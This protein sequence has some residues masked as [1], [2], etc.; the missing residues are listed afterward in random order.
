MR[1]VLLSLALAALFAAACMAMPAR[2]ASPYDSLR[3]ADLCP[4]SS[5][6][7][8]PRGCADDQVDGDLDG[9]CDVGAASDGPSRCSGADLCPSTA[10]AEAVDAEGCAPS[11]TRPACDPGAD[12][13]GDGVCDGRDLCP[14][15]LDSVDAAG[16]A[17]DQ[18]DGDFDGT[19]DAGAA[20]S[21]P[22]GC[23]RIDLC[24]ASAPG[25]V[26]ANGCG[27]ELREGVPVSAVNADGDAVCDI[28][29]RSSGVEGCRGFDLCGQTPAVAATD[30]RGCAQPDVDGDADDVCDIGAET[31]GPDE[32]TGA[33]LC[34]ATASGPV[35]PDGCSATDVKA[36]C[37][38][39]EDADGDGVCDAR[40]RCPG[41]TQG[42]DFAGCARAQ[43]DA[44]ADGACDIDAESPGPFLCVGD[45]HCGAS[46]PAAVDVNGCTLQQVDADGD[47][48]CD[49]GARSFG[50]LPHCETFDSD[51]DLCSDREELGPDP[52]AGGSRDRWY[53]WDFFDAT[54]DRTADLS[55][56]LEVL[57][58][59]GHA[60][61][62]DPSDAFL[63]RYVPDPSH[64]FRTAQA[65]GGRAGI[66]LEDA[67]AALQSFGHSCAAYL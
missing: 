15:S 26:D 60:P 33:D 38:A 44:D 43:V 4:A 7:A 3:G 25:A 56:A 57:S 8:D 2:A 34:P 32:C 47:G 23:T 58:H 53:F 63:D 11:D 45:D 6:P 24:P 62:D 31:R 22:S 1:S 48:I 30:E 28:D 9:V 52:L 46:P 41:S 17:D 66:T 49:A 12:A 42:V 21:G 51:G 67:L 39:S 55:D 16:C 14:G 10:P 35:D 40:D 5:A 20:S 37:I 13:D 59:F 61:G 18:V 65:T 27:V 36:P 29:A 64:A 19:C 50:P 54:G